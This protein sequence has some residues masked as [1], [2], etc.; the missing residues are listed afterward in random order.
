MDSQIFP[1]VEVNV[2]DNLS[3]PLPGSAVKITN[4]T[5]RF[6]KYFTIHT[7]EMYSLGYDLKPLGV[8]ILD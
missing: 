2:I 3:R 1:F 6:T 8:K 5:A 4:E 7:N